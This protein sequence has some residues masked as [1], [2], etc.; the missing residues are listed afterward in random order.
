M[1]FL[2]QSTAVTVNVGPFIDDTTGKD[3]ETGLTEHPAD[4]LLAKN[5]GNFG[6]KNEASNLTHDNLGW[7]HCP[8]DETDTNTLGRLQ[9]HCHEAG[10]L[11][12]FHEYTVLPANIFDSLISGSAADY[13]DIN[14]AQLGGVTQSATDL[15]DF[16]DTGYNPATHKVVGVVT[17]DTTTTNTDV[18]ALQADVGD[19]SASTLGSIYAILGNPAALAIKTSVE[20]IHTD[21]G[22]AITNIGDVHATDLPALKTV[23]DDI[24]AT[25]LPAVK[26]DTGA[27]KAITDL[28][29]L[30]AI[31]DAV[32]DET[33]EGAYTERQLLKII[34]AAVAGKTSEAVAGTMVVRDVND[35]ANRISA[36]MDANRYRTGVALTV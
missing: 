22:T 3:A 30:A 35:T 14:V 16:A 24:H 6:A 33:V 31:A 26:S 5:G 2:K 28:L 11:P 23:V 25:D 8:I 36:T 15:T 18:T 10:F 27:I 12:V 32:H 20:D 17:V 4:I 7:Y 1:L 34:S 13:L 21:V 29:T 19:A 9:L